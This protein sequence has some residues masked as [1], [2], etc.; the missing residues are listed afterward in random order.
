MTDAQMYFVLN[1]ETPSKKNSRISLRNGKTIP[2]KQY[3]E[4]HKDAVFQLERQKMYSDCH[5]P[6]DTGVYITLI[7]Y[8][9]DNRRRDS[10]NGTSS[11]FDT[12]QDANILTDD[13][14]QI[15][16]GFKVLNKKADFA[17]CEIEIIREEE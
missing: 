14:W 1:G 5:F 10:D 13:R 4:W 11:I 12:L 16:R 17:K 6:I 2:S 15:I 7:F 9:A 8:H 3:K